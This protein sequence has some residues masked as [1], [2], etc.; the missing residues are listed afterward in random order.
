MS[1]SD[2]DL[3][4]ELI[5]FSSK[6]TIARIGTDVAFV[7]FGSKEAAQEALNTSRRKGVYV[8]NSRLSIVPCHK[9]E[10]RFG[11][12]YE[13]RSPGGDISCSGL[14]QD[15]VPTTAIYVMCIEESASDAELCKAFLPFSSNVKIARF[16]K[17]KA[18]IC[19]GSKEA[20][21]ASDAAVGR[22]HR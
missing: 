18:F 2:K 13:Q 10:V 12:C 3:A 22:S 7:D 1:A 4:R 19:L 21:G 5:S 17:S 8:G 15:D 11:T 9:T 14:H 16:Q 6:L 20:A